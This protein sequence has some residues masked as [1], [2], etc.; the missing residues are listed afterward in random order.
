MSSS[1]AAYLDTSLSMSPEARCLSLVIADWI[2]LGVKMPPH[3][4]LHASD[5]S[6]LQL[7]GDFANTVS[8][9]LSKF[10]LPSSRQL[11]LI[12]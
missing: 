12:G 7:L 2:Q 5:V 10:S 11:G 4:C 9:L 1:G 6:R 8:R 3:R